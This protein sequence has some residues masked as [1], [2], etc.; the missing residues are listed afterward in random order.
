MLTSTLNR[1]RPALMAVAVLFAFGALTASAE[2]KSKKPVSV[3]PAPKTPVASD[4]TTFSFRGLKPK[5]LGPVKVI[6]SKTGRHG[7]KRI[8]HPDGKG[9][10]FDPNGK[11]APGETVRVYTRKKIK[12][13][14]NGDFYVKIGRFYGND[15]KNASPPG[16]QSPNP[17]LKSRPDLKPAEL[18]VLTPGD[19]AAPGK[20]FYA[21]AQYGM[22]IADNYGRTYWWRAVSFGGKGDRV[23]NFQ[24]QQYNG[25][26]VVTYWKGANTVQSFT[27]VGNFEVLNQKYNRIFRF[28]PGNGYKPDV[29]DFQITPRNTALV[30]A[31]RGVEWDLSKYGGDKDGRILDN[32]IQEVDMKTGAVLFE[33]HSLGN[34]GLG[35]SSTAPQPGQVWDYFHLNAAHW[36]GKGILASARATSTLYRIKRANA[37]MM[38]RLRGDGAK[39]KANS[40]KVAD[41]AMFGYQHDVRRT[42]EGYISLFDNG[43]QGPLVVNPTSSGLVLKLSGKG[44]NRTASLVKRFSYPGQSLDFPGP[45]PDNP[46]SAQGMQTFATGGTLELENGNFL[47]GWGTERNITEFDPNG[48]VVFDAAWPRGG[49][50]SYRA[51]KGVWNG[52]P[53]DR[54]SIASEGAGAG[55]KVWASWNGATKIAE[56]KVLTGDSADS[57]QEV[58]SSPWKGLETRIDVPS[59]ESKVRVVAY[60]RNGNKLDESGLI[61]LGEQSR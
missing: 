5:N 11:F 28:G 53:K 6:G 47:V 35:A 15:D 30:L 22:A 12:L 8:K 55:A 37:T 19:N 4:T 24:L 29:H 1:L 23:G 39:P 20:I 61:A 49:F 33:W 46:H 42:S 54:P 43:F 40:F 31:Y 17:R 34:V 2:A 32:I 10:S 56:W 3:Y 16:D 51:S 36:D 45:N 13:T 25:N 48:N 60:D 7:G 41:D 27:Q 57:L 18:Q 26:P 9:V 52:K 44:N 50:F 38:W 59:V 58:G 14:N 21:P